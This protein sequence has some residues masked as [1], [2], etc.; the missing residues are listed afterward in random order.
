MIKWKSLP[1]YKG[2][3]EVSPLGQIRNQPKRGQTRSKVLDPYMRRGYLFIELWKDGAHKKIAL[4]RIIAKAYLKKVEGKDHVNH[5]N[6][7][8]YDNRVENLEWCTNHEN[9]IHAMD[10]GLSPKA[11]PQK[12]P[13]E[14][15]LARYNRQTKVVQFTA[16]GTPIAVFATMKEAAM[17]VGVVSSTLFKAVDNPNY[18]CAE[19]Y[20]KAYTGEPLHWTVDCGVGSDERGIVSIFGAAF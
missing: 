6:G 9:I 1:G 16:S 7:V 5:K 19:H 11:Y 20:W 18:K 3:Y 14:T 13:D 10:M 15:L 4:H 12:Q 2:L 8:K 17:A